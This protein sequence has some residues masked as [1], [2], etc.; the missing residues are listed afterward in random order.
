MLVSSPRTWGCFQVFARAAGLG[1]VFPTHVGVFPCR[2]RTRSRCVCLPHARGGVSIETSSTERT[3]RSSPR[4]WGCFLVMHPEIE[5]ARVF[6]THVGVF[7]SVAPPASPATRLP[8]ARGGVSEQ[9][10]LAL[11]ELWSSPRT[12]GCFSLISANAWVSPVFPTHVGVFP[13]VVRWRAFR[14]RLPHARGGVSVSAEFDRLTARSSPRTWG[15]F[16]GPAPRAAR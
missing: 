3:S 13:R 5:E 4:T 15:C 7:L 6:P 11:Y 8:H 14:L 10:R 12:W 16:L 2:L 9:K 1:S